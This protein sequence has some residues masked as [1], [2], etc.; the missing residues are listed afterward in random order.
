MPSAPTKPRPMQRDWVV[1]HD[2]AE[3]QTIVARL[4]RPPISTNWVSGP[5]TINQG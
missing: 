5:I 3:L 1:E 2:D 4:H